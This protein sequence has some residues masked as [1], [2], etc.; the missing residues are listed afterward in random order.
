[1]WIIL[2]IAIIVL[3]FI[4]KK[5]SGMFTNVTK[6]P[7]F[8]KALEEA[9]MIKRFFLDSTIKNGGNVSIVKYDVDNPDNLIQNLENTN[10]LIYFRIDTKLTYSALWPLDDSDFSPEERAKCLEKIF[11][12][13]FEK[14]IKLGI[15]PYRDLAYRDN[16]EKG[17]IYYKYLCPCNLMGDER[18][19]FINALE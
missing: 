18:D 9:K 14:I 7:E 2:I 6:Q 4:F 16:L 1:M 8:I 12:A 11:G 10:Q 17:I 19:V 3:V 13:D 15:N 5:I